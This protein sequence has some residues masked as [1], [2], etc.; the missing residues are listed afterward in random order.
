MPIKTSDMEYEVNKLSEIKEWIGKEKAVIEDSEKI[1]SKKI[2][3]LKKEARGRYNEELETTQQLYAITSKSLN[4]FEESKEQPYF[5]R[6]DFREYKREEEIF[7]IGK[8]GLG[9]SKE[10]EEIIIDWRAPIADLYYSGTQGD[11]YYRAPVGVISGELNLKRKFLIR[12]GILKDAFDEGINEIILKSN[13]FNGKELIDEFLKINLEESS[14]GKLKDVVATIQR[15]QNEIIRVEKN[16]IILIQGSAGSGKT[17]VAL[18]RLAYLLYKYIDKIKAGEVLVIAPSEIFLDYISQILPDLG[19]EEVVQNTYEGILTKILNLKMKLISKNKKLIDIIENVQFEDEKYSYLGFKGSME[20]KA[21]LDK[22]LLDIEKDDSEVLDITYEGYLLFNKEDIMRLYSVDFVN[23]SV[24]KRKEEIRRY[25]KLKIGDKISSVLERIEFGYGYKIARVKKLE[26]D[27]PDRRKQLFDLYEERDLKKKIIQKRLRESFEAYFTNWESR[28]YLQLYITLFNEDKYESLFK[29]YLPKKNFLDMKEEFNRNYENQVIDSDDLAP[30]FYL[31]YR[32]EGMESK[33]QFKHIVVDEAQDYNMFQLYILKFMAINNSIT[34]VGDIG[35]CIYSYKGIKDWKEL[36]EKAFQNKTRYK[37]LTQSYRSTV[38]IIEFANRVLYK[39]K[40]DLIPA[41]PVFRHG[42]PPELIK[43]GKTEDLLKHLLNINTVIEKAGKR[44]IAIIC[45]TLGDCIALDKL[46]KKNK[47]DNW[48]L[49]KEN[50]K[51]LGDKVII[52]S[53]MTK[54]LEFDCSIVFDCDNKNYGD[55]ELDRK[56]LY[57]VLTRALH[58]EY[59][60]YKEEPS[61]LL[62]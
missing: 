6:I 28:N 19:V 34:L 37:E 50:Q 15:E 43:Y 8:L 35:Q 27:S 26:E 25:F 29:G 32:L 52:P 18:H 17:T 42:T 39:Q 41:K 56:I 22:Y 44:S 49:V 13:N 11:T 9:D 45:K 20:F 23:L 31:K 60:F 14:S 21:I 40:L 10:N 54:G 58:Y 2:G 48:Q 38:E 46:L 62:E 7:Y 4:N 3:G 61:S 16:E 36:S 24:K 55:K 51:A 12:E 30:I 53:Y 33:W 57:V 59:V 1:L 47:V 5:A